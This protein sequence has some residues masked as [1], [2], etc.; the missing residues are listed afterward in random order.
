LTEYKEAHILSTLAAG[1][2]ESGDFA[3]AI[4]WSTKAVELGGHE[5]HEQLEQLKNE[6]DSYQQGKPWREKQEVKEKKPPAIK[7]QDA[8]ET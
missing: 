4:K 6:L 8:I 3:E 7:P 1:Y 2:A 5:G